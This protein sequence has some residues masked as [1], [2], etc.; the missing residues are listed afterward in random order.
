MHGIDALLRRGDVLPHSHG[1]VGE[2][3]KEDRAITNATEKVEVSSETL[4]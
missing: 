2:F 4:T 3:D 1:D